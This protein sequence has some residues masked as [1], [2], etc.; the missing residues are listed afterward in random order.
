M[1]TEATVR[2]DGQK[3]SI[4]FEELVTG[5]VILL[6]SGDKVP[7]DLRLMAVRG[8]DITLAFLVEPASA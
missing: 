3:R 8:R 5:D 7:A 1:K 4:P 6:K 2:R